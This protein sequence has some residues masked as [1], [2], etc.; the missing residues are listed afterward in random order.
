MINPYEQ[1]GKRR[2]NADDPRIQILSEG[3]YCGDFRV[4]LGRHGLSLQDQ[5]NDRFDFRH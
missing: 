4:T 1:L 3:G 5:D 2:Y